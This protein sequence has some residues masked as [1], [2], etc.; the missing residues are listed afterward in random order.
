TGPLSASGPGDLTRWMAVPWQTDDASCGAPLRDPLP[1]WWPARVPDHVISER[2]YRQIMDSSLSADERLRFFTQREE[3]L[4]H[5]QQQP[6]EA[7]INDMI[8]KWSQIG[9]ILEQPGPI[10][11][12]APALP[13]TLF[14][15]LESDF[16]EPGLPLA[17]FETHLADTAPSPPPLRHPQMW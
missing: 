4:R 2:I 5:L 7:R 13:D 3:W 16:P 8:Q 11:P 1:A 9:I 17:D 14:V 6:Y 10:D 15:E 12:G